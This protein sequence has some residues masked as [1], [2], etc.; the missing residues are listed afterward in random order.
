MKYKNHLK[1]NNNNNIFF[2][3]VSFASNLHRVNQM[4]PVTLAGWLSLD[5][6]NSNAN[7]WF[8]WQLYAGWTFSCHCS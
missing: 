6:Q 4:Y 8:V 2:F 5:Q 3:Y 1:I 7:G